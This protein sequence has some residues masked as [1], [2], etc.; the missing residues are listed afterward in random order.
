[1]LFEEVIGNAPR[2]DYKKRLQILEKMLLPNADL[3][4]LIIEV[5]SFTL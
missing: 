5:S 2:D 3:K 1:M 4:A